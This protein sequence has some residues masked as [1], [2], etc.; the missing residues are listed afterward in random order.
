M[1][2]QSLPKQAIAKGRGTVLKRFCFTRKVAEFMARKS[3]GKRL[4]FEIFKRDNF[5]CQYCGDQPPDVVLVIDHIQPVSKGGDNDPMNLITACE[6]CNQGKSDKT[7]D[8]TIPRPDADLEWLAMQQ[9]I[10]EL[11]RYQLAKQKRN[12]LIDEITCDLTEIFIFQSDTYYD[13]DKTANE[14]LRILNLYSPDITEEALLNTAIKVKGGYLDKWGWA[15]YT[16][17]TLRNMVN[18][19]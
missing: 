17:G 18:E 1:P 8:K 3:T 19:R 11:E 2:R 10:K 16:Y 14:V 9:E 15:K 12:I 6:P 7:I 4:R 5:T 13:F